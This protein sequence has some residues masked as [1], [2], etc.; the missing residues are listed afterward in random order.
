[1]LSSN[2]QYIHEDIGGSRH[3]CR[4][5]DLQIPLRTIEELYGVE[6][7]AMETRTNL[8]MAP[9]GQLWTCTLQ[10]TS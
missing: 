6:H 3:R 5:V 9:K 8:T 10:E 4:P 7:F 2:A 1:M